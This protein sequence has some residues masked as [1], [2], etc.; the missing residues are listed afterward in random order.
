MLSQ[1]RDAMHA[2]SVAPVKSVKRSCDT[3][4][5]SC[6]MCGPDSAG[7]PSLPHQQMDPSSDGPALGAG[8]LMGIRTRRR[9]CCEDR[10][11]EARWRPRGAN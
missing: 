4:R 10:A 6:V 7:T 5:H 9:C 2:F 8:K 11:Q 3:E 1:R